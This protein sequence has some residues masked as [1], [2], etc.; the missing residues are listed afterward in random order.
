MNLRYVVTSDVITYVYH[1]SGANI[2]SNVKMAA[3]ES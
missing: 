3:V 2:V 1:I